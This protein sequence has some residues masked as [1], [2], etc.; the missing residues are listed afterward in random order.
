VILV[1]TSLWIDWSRRKRYGLRPVDYRDFVTCGPFLQELLQG[2]DDAD[3]ATD[4]RDGLLE[5]ERLDDPVPLEAFLDAAEIYSTGRRRGY[6]IRSSFDCLIA[7]IA[8]RHKV[9]VW[10]RDRDFDLIARFTG[11]RTITQFPS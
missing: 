9:V 6:T 8:I 2:M 5:L 4:L 3:L 10:H 11:L 1:D 7:A